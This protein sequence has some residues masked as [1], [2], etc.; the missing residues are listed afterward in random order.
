MGPENARV[1]I[2]EPVPAAVVPPAP[3]PAPANP[4]PLSLKP[5]VTGD[6]EAEE[7]V[8]ER[9]EAPLARLRD[10]GAD[11]PRPDPGAPPPEESLR[12]LRRSSAPGGVV[13][14]ADD[15][16]APAPP[17]VV[18]GE[19]MAGPLPVHGGG[20]G[21]S[22]AVLRPRADAGDARPMAPMAPV[23]P[24]EPIAAPVAPAPAP[25]APGPA[26]V[27][28]VPVAVP[29]VEPAARWLE[30]GTTVYVRS[31]RPIESFTT[32][33]GATRH[34][35]GEQHLI[36]TGDALWEV[37]AEETRSKNPFRRGKKVP[38]AVVGRRTQIESA[39]VDV[40]G[41]LSQVSVRPFQQPVFVRKSAVIEDRHEATKAPLFRPRPGGDGVLVG[42]EDIA[43]GT[44]ADCWLES[45]LASLAATNPKAVTDMV[46]EDGENAVI[47]R[48]Y[49]KKPRPA[50]PERTE[51]RVART[52]AVGGSGAL[53][54]D[55]GG[56]GG[57]I[58]PAMIEKAWAAG[59]FGATADASAQAPVGEARYAD[60]GWGHLS[61]AFEV[62]TGVPA[63]DA[64][65]H[66]MPP[67][68]YPSLDRLFAV[69]SNDLGPAPR[70]R[71]DAWFKTN[72]AKLKAAVQLQV[73]EQVGEKDGKP[74]IE[75]RGGMLRQEQFGAILREFKLPDDLIPLV[76]ENLK[77][78]L[79]G[80][81]GTGRY[82]DVM[83]ERWTLVSEALQ[84]GKLVGAQTR[85]TKLMGSNPDRAPG[86]GV[87]E[88]KFRGLA[89]THAYSIHG[90]KEEPGPVGADGQAQTVKFIKV[91]N[92]WGHYERDYQPKDGGALK[93]VTAAPKGPA[94]PDAGFFWVELSDFVKRFDAVTVSGKSVRADDPAAAGA[95]AA[96]AAE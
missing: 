7:V 85:E 41:E 17:A 43:Q 60:L 94:A 18:D 81:R 59:R 22:N 52:R 20:R 79:P 25:V 83:K 70:E 40:G 74:Q 16:V 33:G 92:P 62:L 78:L 37:T 36:G 23:A 90:I 58:W 76:L 68:A 27:A 12:R 34:A 4:L 47:V 46:R 49:R 8:A 6:V 63:K 69:A 80:K 48:L 35:A 72:E 29:L 51:V 42:P 3:T 21:R 86:D 19:Q 13:R 75:D 31:E 26:P 32:L 44:L 50:Q 93:A 91:R 14:R 61:H 95:A 1:S 28:P 10:K 57:V 64:D 73:G 65:L 45:A 67:N 87:G 88:H 5:P 2:R 39:V 89:A 77:K 71:W 15:D 96:P 11:A 56:V 54:F 82:T 53:S 84:E 66:R 24:A 55:K 30:A 38:T 9:T